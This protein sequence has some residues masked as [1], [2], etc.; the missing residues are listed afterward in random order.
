MAQHMT[1][2]D[3]PTQ[4]GSERSS[5]A[6]VAHNP[7]CRSDAS[8]CWKFYGGTRISAPAPCQQT[9]GARASPILEAKMERCAWTCDLFAHLSGAGPIKC[10]LAEQ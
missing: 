1:V 4:R 2:Q 5:A 3:P 10:S 9:S 8:R 7:S 6:R